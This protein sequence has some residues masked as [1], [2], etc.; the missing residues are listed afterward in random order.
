MKPIVAPQCVLL[1]TLIAAYCCLSL[2]PIA[3]FNADY[4]CPSIAT[5]LNDCGYRDWSN[6]KQTVKLLAGRQQ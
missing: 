4:C 5:P 2:Q 3:A 1:L 6:S